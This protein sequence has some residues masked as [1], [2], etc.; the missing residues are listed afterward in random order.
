[1]NKYY[2]KLVRT[3]ALSL[4]SITLLIASIALLSLEALIN[5]IF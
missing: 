5:Y 1:M 3:A 4:F 2:D